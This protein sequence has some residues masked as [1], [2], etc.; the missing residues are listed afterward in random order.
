[1]IPR[2]RTEF[3]WL[4]RCPVTGTMQNPS[5]S[6]IFQLISD[7]IGGS[8]ENRQYMPKPPR[9]TL[10]KQI[11]IDN[12]WRHARALFDSKG[13]VRRDRVRIAGKEESHPEGSYF[14]EWWDK[15]KRFC[16]PARGNAQDAADRARVKQAELTAVRNGIVPEPP[17][18]ETVPD[19]TPLPAALD[20]YLDYVRD[21]RSLR[22]FRTV[23]FLGP[24]K[25]FARKPISTKLS[26]RTF[27][28]S[29][30]TA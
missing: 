28:T 6:V 25:P 29:P 9:V 20:S 10:L 19:R 3:S 7:P 24:S 26:A 1:L 16:E 17:K 23:L 12:K 27:S 13:R 22:T 15:G 30:R 8:P 18:P 2:L 4:E 5:N 11:K 14:I 21:H